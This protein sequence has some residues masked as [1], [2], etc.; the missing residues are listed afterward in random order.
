[1]RFKLTARGC[2]VG[3]IITEEG[4]TVRVTLDDSASDSDS[5]IIDCDTM[6]EVLFDRTGFCLLLFKHGVTEIVDIDLFNR[7][8]LGPVFGL[9]EWSRL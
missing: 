8:N 7:T 5:I 4:D 2:E 6:Q 1:M 9:W 3:C